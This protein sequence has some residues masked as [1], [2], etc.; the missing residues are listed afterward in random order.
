MQFPR[1]L[2]SAYTYFSS[3]GLLPRKLLDQYLDKKSLIVALDFASV[4][5]TSGLAPF[6]IATASSKLDPSGKKASIEVVD[7]R[8]NIAL[9]DAA[10]KG[11]QIDC[12]ISFRCIVA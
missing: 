2:R 5:K 11:Y 3:L 9:P 8:V 12:S 7:I 1:E 4:V 6:V 10:H